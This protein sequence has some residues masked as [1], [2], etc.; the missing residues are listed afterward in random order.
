MGGDMA[1]DPSILLNL[2]TSDARGYPG[3]LYEYQN[4]GITEFAIR[5]LLILKGA[6]LVVLGLQRG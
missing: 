5:K 4:K 1:I 6:I 3:I 2:P